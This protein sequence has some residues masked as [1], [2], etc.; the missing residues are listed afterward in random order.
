MGKTVDARNASYTSTIGD[1]ELS[2]VWSGSAFDLPEQGC[3][4]RVRARSI[5]LGPY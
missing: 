5:R 4:Y 1:N 2:A 3:G